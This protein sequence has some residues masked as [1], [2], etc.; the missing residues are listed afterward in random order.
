MSAAAAPSSESSPVVAAVTAKPWGFWATVG[1]SVLILI[2]WVIVQLLA[3]IVYFVAAPGGREAFHQIMSNS[4]KDVLT[5]DG[6]VLA[7]L[8][9]FS[10]LLIPPVCVFFAW[11][12]RGISVP[13]YLG[14][15]NVPLRQWLAW[16]GVCLLFCAGS[17][18]ANWLLHRPIVP[19]FMDNVYRSTAFMP[20]LW[21]AVVIGAPLYEEF[22]FRG[23]VLAGFRYSWPRSVGAV[24]L[25]SLGWAALH[26]QYEFIDVADL[27]LFGLILGYARIRTGSLYIPIG[28]H[29][30]NNLWATIE[31]AIKVHFSP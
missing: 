16:S 10:G 9:T 21:F 23:F 11:L 20:L 13:D 22:V 12:R 6:T 29:A 19:E 1:F 30:L 3:T 8:G 7:L 4:N 24:L 14:L 28:M 2:A 26:T 25:T 17:D 31:V 5:N 18:T 27:F 15:R